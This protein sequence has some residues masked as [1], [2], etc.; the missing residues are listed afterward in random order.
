ME[1]GQYYEEFRP[2]LD[3]SAR[4]AIYA[5]C[6]RSVPTPKAAK[7]IYSEAG[8]GGVKVGVVDGLGVRCTF[9][10]EAGVHVF[11]IHNL[12]RSVLVA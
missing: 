12:S 4:I 2:H 1:T 7:P 8:S 9:I 5:E 6:Q 3:V 10:R 11:I